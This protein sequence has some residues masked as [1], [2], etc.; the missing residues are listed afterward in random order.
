MCALG[1]SVP[2]HQLAEIMGSVF[3]AS[4]PYMRVPLPEPLYASIKSYSHASAA[5][6][7][8]SST[9]IGMVVLLAALKMNEGVV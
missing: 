7:F 3:N 4:M 6:S 2:T 9:T 1:L 5:F 8:T